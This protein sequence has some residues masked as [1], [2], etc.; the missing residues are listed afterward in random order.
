MRTKYAILVYTQCSYV[1]RTK[2]YH[3]NKGLPANTGD[4]WA[5]VVG[6]KF[7]KVGYS[8]KFNL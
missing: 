6:E 4:G 1:T 3:G 5:T 8:R 7:R 2:K